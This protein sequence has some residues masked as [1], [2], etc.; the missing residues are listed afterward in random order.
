MN[1]VPKEVFLTSGVG[2]HKEKLT[3]FEMALRDAFISNFNLVKVSSILPP[4]CKVITK[5]KGLMKLNA[6]QVVYCVMSSNQT[7]EPHRLISASIGL[8]VPGDRNKY[9]YLSEHHSFGESNG[10]AG[11]YAEDLAAEML[12]TTLGI[13]N[14]E[15]EWN[16]RKKTWKLNKEI[17]RT[18]NVTQSTVGEKNGLWTSVIAAAIFI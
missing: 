18:S 7:N 12:A 16:E 6:G 9:G 3:S 1:Y 8:A 17:V 5:E 2:K 10:K 13:N 4:H 15:I 11:D 14:E